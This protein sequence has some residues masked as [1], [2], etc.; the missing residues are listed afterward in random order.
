[1][2]GSGVA[3]ASSHFATQALSRFFQE[4]TCRGPGG[5][6]LLVLGLVLLA[7]LDNGT[8]GLGVEAFSPYAN[9]YATSGLIIGA[10]FGAFSYFSPIFTEVTGFTPAVV[11]VLL[12]VY[13]IANVVGNMVVGGL[14]VL[15]AALVVLHCLPRPPSQRHGLHPHRPGRRPDEPSDD[16]LRHGRGT[17]GA[18][19]EHLYHQH[20]P[21][22]RCLS[23]W[24][25]H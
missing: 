5:F 23:R 12:G 17:S 3:L 15:S 1:M 7:E 20:W 22:L 11:P 16:R 19:R 18:A 13:G 10:T 25:R 6:V 4:A 2:R 24:R 9:V 14:I 21:R 8:D